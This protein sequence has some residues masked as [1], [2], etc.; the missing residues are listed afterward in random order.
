MSRTCWSVVALLALLAGPA[1]ADIV[2]LA[3][4]RVLEGSVTVSGTTVIIRHRLGE[5]RVD[6]SQIVKVEETDDVWDQLDRL[7]AELAQGTADER[8]RFA[9]FCRENG[10]ADDARKAFLSVL[11]VDTD[12]PGARAALGYVKVDGRWVTVE[13]RNRALGLVQHEGEWMTPEARAARVEQTRQAAE[14]R[15]AEREAEQARARARREAEREATAQARRERAELYAQELARERAR[16]RALDSYERPNGIYSGYNVL[17]PWGGV[18]VFNGGWGWGGGFYRPPCPVVVPRGG[19]GWGVGSQV[20]GSYDG[21]R[22]Q[23]NWRF[24]F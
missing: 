23:L 18:R 1:S 8:Y 4:G 15:K 24:G 7:R 17:N 12:H 3:D 13:D 22:W 2:T 16:Q 19:A 11:R 5:V 9:V 10:F 21:G 20:R 6:R 14:A